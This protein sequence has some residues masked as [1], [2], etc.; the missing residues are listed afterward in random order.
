MERGQERLPFLSMAAR[1]GSPPGPPRVRSKDVPCA[2]A[3]RGRAGRRVRTAGIFARRCAR[4]QMSSTLLLSLPSEL[5]LFGKATPPGSSKRV[6]HRPRACMSGRG[7]SCASGAC[8]ASPWP[9]WT[10]RAPPLGRG[11]VSR[12]PCLAFSPGSAGFLPGGA[13]GDVIPSQIV[14]GAQPLEKGL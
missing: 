1:D 9:M 11:L 7:G 4:H 8:P 6:R 12:G 10:V 5:G 3:G 2:C 14:N 13:T